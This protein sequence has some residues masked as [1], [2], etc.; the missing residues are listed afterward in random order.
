[1]TGAII[2][3]ILYPCAD[4]RGVDEFQAVAV[5]GPDTFVYGVSEVGSVFGCYGL[6]SLG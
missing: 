5:F 6:F 1:M 2:K 4:K 3:P